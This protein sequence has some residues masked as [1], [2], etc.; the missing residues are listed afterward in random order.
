METMA[1]QRKKNTEAEHSIRDS[2]TGLVSHGLFQIA[3]ERDINRSERHN[4]PLTLAMIDIDLFSKINKQ[5]GHVE[6]DRILKM[7]AGLIEKNIRQADMAARYSGDVFAVILSNAPA[8]T[9]QVAGD[10][11]LRAVQEEFQGSPTVSIGLASYPV[12]GM[13]RDTLIRRS[14]EALSQAKIRGKNRLFY[15]Q[16]EEQPS[17]GAKA[18]VLLVD[19]DSANL[20]LMEAL[21][22]PQGYDVMK[23]KDGFEA[24]S[25]INRT[26]VDL[27]LLDIIMP[28]MD[29]YE[30]CR[31]LKSIEGQRMTPVIMITAKDRTDTKIKAI[32]AG[33]DDF[34]PKP[35]RKEELLARM[36]SLVGMKRLNKNLTSIEN[37][38]FAMAIAVEA[39]DSYTQGHTK[40]VAN[41]ATALGRKMGLA[42]EQVAALRLG[43]ILHDVGKI[44]VSGSILNKPGPL[45]PDEWEKMKSHTELGYKICL[46]LKETLGAAL[47]VV[48]SH[49]EKMDGSSY[50]DGLKGDEIPMAARIMATVDI[51]D[52]LV[53]DRPY[54][55]AMSGSRALE[56]LKEEAEQGKLDPMVVE[57]L[58]SMMGIEETQEEEEKARADV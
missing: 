50:P 31:R 36:K 28:G 39:K 20:K 24:L 17:Q 43:G 49:H 57:S 34:I 9:A 15:S 40:R 16:R 2:L 51:Y 1:K 11:I 48:R 6:G 3:L 47:E 21:L 23:A 13:T 58:V 10:R 12:D 4:E 44:G 25:M 7:V 35:V 30:V 46:P 27:V 41:L 18:K 52:A 22:L 26:G 5:L 33:A 42:E 29:G 55:P 19:D 8:E 53:T 56:I 32:E 38:L 54:R 37:V 45:D 14:M